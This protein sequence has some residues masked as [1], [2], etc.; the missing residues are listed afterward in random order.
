MVTKKEEKISRAGITVTKRKIKPNRD[1]GR[2]IGVGNFIK[3]RSAG[4][5]ISIP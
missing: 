3:I 2:V 4:R 5:R 1:I